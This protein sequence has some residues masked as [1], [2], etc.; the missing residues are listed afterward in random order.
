MVL[1]SYIHLFNMFSRCMRLVVFPT[2]RFWLRS[3]VEARLGR[4]PFPHIYLLTCNPY[5]LALVTNCSTSDPS[6]SH[7]S[8]RPYESSMAEVPAPSTVL[9]PSRRSK[10]PATEPGDANIILYFKRKTSP[11]RRRR[12]TTHA[13]NKHQRQT[14]RRMSRTH[15]RCRPIKGNRSQL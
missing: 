5:L 14:R 10:E 2:S 1:A 13:C 6:E 4:K 8:A 3:N 11:P 9:K 15:Q 12:G 7:P